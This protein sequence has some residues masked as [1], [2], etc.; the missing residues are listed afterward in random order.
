MSKWIDN[1]YNNSLETKK[2][3]TILIYANGNNELEPEVYKSFLDLQKEPI[4]DNINTIVQL[5][6][7]PKDLVGCLRQNF[8]FGYDQEWHGVHRYKI[9]NRKVE[10][11][12]DL[13]NI[14]MADPQTFFDFVTW[15]IKQYPSSKIMVI[16]SGH[17]AG[18]VGLMTDYTHEYPY[19]M[20]MN[21]LVS[22]LYKIKYETRQSIDCM[23]LDACYMNM[24]ELWNEI[25]LIPNK[26]VKYLL[27]PTKN[28]L[29]EG[30][31]YY[32]IIR[33]LQQYPMSFSTRLYRSLSYI[34]RKFNSAYEDY[35]ILMTVKLKKRNF[36]RLKKNIDYM[37]D[38]IYKN[39]IKLRDEIGKWCYIEGKE[40]LISLL[41]LESLFNSR[42]YDI[43][44]NRQNLSRILSKI[45]V[46]PE[47]KKIPKKLNQGPCIYLPIFSKQYITLKLYYNNLLFSKDNRWL[48]VLKGKENTGTYIIS[49]ENKQYNTK[50]PPVAIPITYI[51]A[52]IL[53]QNPQITVEEAWELVKEMGWYTKY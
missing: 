48:N 24:V 47:F 8:C 18:F 10:K 21:G 13:G 45:I 35:N 44:S 31:P 25:A 26:P 2:K 39:N 11:I 19:I 32:L 7:A 33:Y 16:I 22:S 36:I 51:V 41:D 46:Y 3:W 9:N 40:P 1:L 50:Y 12:E 37:G 53:Q 38:L 5:G 34:T 42:F 29:L 4:N 30:L 6:R 27:A 43:Y 20:D 49:N 14:N 23:V 17:G 28:V 15:G 52:V